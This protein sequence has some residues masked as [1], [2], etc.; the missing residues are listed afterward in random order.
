MN[1]QAAHYPSPPPRSSVSARFALG[2]SALLIAVVGN[3]AFASPA[4]AQTLERIRETGHI[5]LG[6][7]ADARPF[8]YE[9]EGKG[10]QGYTIT[11]CE[12]IAAQVKSELSMPGLTL[13]WKAVKP[14]RALEEV[15][16]GNIDVLCAPVS[17]TIEKRRNVSFSLPVFAAG[18]RAVIRTN[19]PQALRNVLTQ[20]SGNKPIWRGSPAAT[21]LTG[22]KVGVAEGTTSEQWLKERIGSLQL[23]AELVPV[24]DYRTGI[25]Q[26]ANGKLDMFFGERTVVLGAL[27]TMDRS[28]REGV[29]ILDRLFTHEPIALALARNND[30]FRAVVDS[31]LS[32][33]YASEQFPS[34]YTKCCGELN[35]EMRSFFSWN[36][37]REGTP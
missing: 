6:Y 31:A 8:S 37:L 33:L 17:V 2:L 9:T 11:L 34:L 3:L 25:Q 4:S 28:A 21:V 15:S 16:E 26:L 24:D 14:D 5:R 32:R 7:F 20:Q 18:N 30:D 29:E 12:H 10:P 35:E 23:D 36:A 27:S 1:M 13:D 22:T 19:A